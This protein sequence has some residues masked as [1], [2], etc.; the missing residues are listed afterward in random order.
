M[1][2][3]PSPGALKLA[4]ELLPLC[5]WHPGGTFGVKHKMEP[6]EVTFAALIDAHTAALVEALEEMA[7]QRTCD[8]MEDPEIAY[9]D[10]KDAYDTFITKA[11]AALA[12][13]RKPVS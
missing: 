5:K 1:T 7:T 3:S 13:W 2:P 12:E 8:E 11:R 6:A 10:F 9:A 4:R